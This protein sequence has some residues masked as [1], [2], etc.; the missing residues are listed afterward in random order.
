MPDKKAVLSCQL[1]SLQAPLR[2]LT[3]MLTSAARS[4]CY[5]LQVH[6]TTWLPKH[7]LPVNS[8][9]LLSMADRLYIGGTSCPYTAWL[10]GRGVSSKVRQEVP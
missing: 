6:L 4:L 10:Q 8:T 3:S 9:S 5:L 2:A 1:G 7:I